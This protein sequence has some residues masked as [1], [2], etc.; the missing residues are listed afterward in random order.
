M[1]K[2][3]KIM[4][5]KNVPKVNIMPLNKNKTYDVNEYTYTKRNDRVQL[6][7]LILSCLLFSYC[8]LTNLILA[9]LIL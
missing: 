9:Y 2:I 5:K 8:I 1:K 6:C 4:Q 7:Y 3:S